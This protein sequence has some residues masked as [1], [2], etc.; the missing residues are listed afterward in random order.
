LQKG[1]QNKR[2]V[3]GILKSF[4]NF[5]KKKVKICGLSKAYSSFLGR[6]QQKLAIDNQNF[7][8]V[9]HVNREDL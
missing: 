7:H 5:I 2:S 1:I 6:V 9:S 8:E 3:I 4:R